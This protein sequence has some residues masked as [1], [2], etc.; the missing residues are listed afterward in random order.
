MY[1]EEFMYKTW[2][3]LRN[4][5]RKKQRFS[6]LDKLFQEDS[7]L[8]PWQYKGNGKK[9]ILPSY[10]FNGGHPVFDTKIK[11][12]PTPK[13]TII[14]KEDEN[15][16]EKLTQNNQ[17]QNQIYPL[18]DFLDSQKEKTSEK[19]ESL[20]FFDL[21]NEI[22]KA[23]FCAAYTSKDVNGKYIYAMKELRK[24]ASDYQLRKMA[25]E[26]GLQLRATKVSEEEKK[27]IIDV[28]NNLMLHG[29]RVKNSDLE[30]LLKR[31]IKTIYKVLKSAGSEVK[32]KKAPKKSINDV[33]GDTNEILDMSYQLNMLLF[34]KS[35][36]R[37]D[38]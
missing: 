26:M 5:F 17:L 6:H 37:G 28:Y 30:R 12:K 11:P 14:K 22:S 25:S 16:I 8:N 23:A 34:Y 35:Q 15:K 21:L 33:K 29:K 36:L 27:H 20:S 3:Y 10:L 2:D 9:I 13:I 38:T 18:F 24:Y 4:F 32:W 1:L 7:N 19:Q 31:N